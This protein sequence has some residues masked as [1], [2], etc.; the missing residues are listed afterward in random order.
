M[1]YTK[2]NLCDVEDAAIRFGLSDTQET[3][4]PAGSSRQSRP[5]SPI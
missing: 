1:S 5:A 4:L 2:I 3:R